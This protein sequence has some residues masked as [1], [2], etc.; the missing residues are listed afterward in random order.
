M[1]ARAAAASNEPEFIDYQPT[2]ED[3]EALHIATWLHD[4]GKVT[5]PEYVVDKATKLETLYD[6]IHEIRMRFEVLK[7]DAW[8]AYWK[9]RAEGGDGSTLAALRDELLTTLDEEF[10]FVARSNLGGEAMA[11]EDL[12][13]LA[14]IA[15]RTWLRT[16]DDRIG[17]SWEE[18]MR[19]QR[20]PKPTSLPVEEKLLA[21]KPEHLFERPASEQIPSDNSLGF[22]LQV[23][24]HRFNRGE[25]YNL[26]IKRGTLTEEERYIIN[27]HIV[28]TILMLNRLPFPSHLQGVA[29][30]AGGHHEK[31]DGT[32]YPK[33]LRREEMSLPAR[34]MAIADIFEAL[35]AVDRP[36][37][38]GKTLS[39][40]LRIMAGMCKSAHI[41][42]PLFAL[43]IRSGIYKNY[44]ERFML[45]EQVDL[46]DE[47]VLMEM[48]GLT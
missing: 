3:W 9:G 16:L 8:I 45:S 10:A 26:G 32:G 40:A 29:E 34:M 23:P 13:R 19:Q 1:L 11:D 41:D 2:D 15:S 27:H 43:F 30:I 7:R 39:E 17:V 33:R 46:V 20:T 28:Q 24:E 14:K 12:Q 21:D 6:R 48:A 42:P 4:C 38:K 18:G 36:Y 47:E 22:K 31:M 25:L 37:K 44:A 5:T 35:T